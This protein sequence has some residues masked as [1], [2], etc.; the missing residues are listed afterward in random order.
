MAVDIAETT[1]TPCAKDPYYAVAGGVAKFVQFLSTSRCD[2]HSS[3]LLVHEHSI[4][5]FFIL[6]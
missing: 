2:Y 5:F 1:Q 4:D 3:I 6:H